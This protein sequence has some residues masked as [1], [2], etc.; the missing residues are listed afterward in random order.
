MAL[1]RRVGKIAGIIAGIVII[2]IVGVLGYA[3]VQWDAK[4]DR[5]V[6]PL[7]A[8][9][10]SLTMQRGEFLFK[11]SL[12]CWLCHSSGDPAAPPSGGMK[13]DL[14]TL[15]PSLG[16]YY[17]ANITPDVETGIGGWTDGEIVRAIREGVRKDGSVLFPIM[18]VDPLSGISDDDA[19]ALVTY[20]RSLPPVKNRVAP[21]EPSLFAKTLFAFG[22]VGPMKEHTAP[23]VAPPRGITAVYGEYVARHASL[24][25]DCHTPRNLQTGTFYYDSLMAGSSIKFGGDNEG[26]SVLAFARNITPDE[27][28]GIGSWTEEQ[29]LTML[30]TGVGADGKVRS[31]HMPY[32]YYGLW[33][34]LEQKAV[35][36]Y[37]RTLRPIRRTTPPNEYV[38]DAIAT[39]PVAKG[40]GLFNATCVACHGAEGKGAPPTNVVLADVAPGLEDGDL[41]TF[42]NE[43]NM[44][45]RMPAF[46]KTLSPDDLKAVLAYIRSWSDQQPSTVQ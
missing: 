36:Q 41:M 14:T 42:I 27:E 5:Q 6:R 32:A 25:S 33:D 43:G 20:L 30:R 8:N 13:F 24:C 18:P 26:S 10:D 4:V 7:V 23:V 38:G 44:G 16:V 37:L 12:T 17:A 29:F 21:K 2:I 9:H 40:K 39:E 45:L 22:V 28:T 35:Y 3:S 15:S 46:G 34:T 19:L 1:A 11:T 31:M